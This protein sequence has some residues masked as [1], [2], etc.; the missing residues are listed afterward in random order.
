M[1]N[2]SWYAVAA[3]LLVLAATI[4]SVLIPDH[5]STTICVALIGVVLSVLSLRDN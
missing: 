4:S 5:G 1:P 2:V 3:L